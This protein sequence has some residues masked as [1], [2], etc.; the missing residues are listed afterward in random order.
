M[1]QYNQSSFIKKKR[2]FF[3][4]KIQVLKML[5]KKEIK[6]CERKYY[7]T[8]LIIVDNASSKKHKFK[9]KVAFLSET[10]NKVLEIVNIQ[11]HL[12]S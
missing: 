4:N 10:L 7:P 6:K 9:K 1:P 12:H 5:I 3:H 8:L 11:I 2:N